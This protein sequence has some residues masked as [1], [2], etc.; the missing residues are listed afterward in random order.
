M[1]IVYN[2]YNLQ[3]LIYNMDHKATIISLLE[4]LKNKELANKEPFKAKAYSTVIKN[5][6]A[7]NVPI[8]S[9]DDLKSVK[10]IGDKIANKLKEYFETG[11]IQAVENVNGDDKINEM[12]EL[13]KIHGIG[14]AKAKSLV[15][16]HNIISIKQLEDNVHLLNDKQK[17]GL[18]YFKDFEERIPRKEMDAHKEFL[19]KNIMQIDSSFTLIMS[20]TPSQT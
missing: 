3:K 9:F 2:L 17:M 8:Q 16:E 7:L 13:M 12:Q 5:I 10:G 20:S 1:N 15:E 4:V 14:P 11:K 18:K 6:L 19:Q